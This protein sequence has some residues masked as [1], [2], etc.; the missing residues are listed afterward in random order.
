LAQQQPSGIDLRI[1]HY[2]EMRRYEK[3]VELI[4]QKLAEEPEDGRLYYLLG[5]CAFNMED[6]HSA[7]NH[8]KQALVLGYEPSIVHGLL[9]R[10]YAELEQW[11][12]AEQAYLEALRESPNDARV[13]AAY[14]YLL[15]KTGHSQKADKLMQMALQL[16]PNDAEVIRYRHLF[17][18]AKEDR[19]EQIR[20]LEQYMQ[21]ADSEISKEIQL[22]LNALY[23]NRTKQAREHFRQAFVLDP[24]NKRLADALNDLDQ[25]QNVLM[26]PMRWIS[27]IGGPAVFW[28]IGIGSISVTRALGLGQVSG[29]LLI[30]YIAW[31][32]YSWL[33]TPLLKLINK[34]RG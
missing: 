2:L 10:T 32:V 26:A 33:A 9:G 11:V 17:G 12:Q 4:G 19:I 15:K 27:R 16:G 23:R 24:T 6:Y 1:E 29:I 34:I 22:G 3:V 13:H 31:V 7:E 28:V 20:A 8:L 18:L 21:M 5:I 14:A 25:V 30:V